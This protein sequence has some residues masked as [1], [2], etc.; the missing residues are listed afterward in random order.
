MKWVPRQAPLTLLLSASILYKFIGLKMYFQ[1]ILYM[2]SL[3]LSSR[4]QVSASS[5]NQNRED[6]GNKADAM[7]S[8]GGGGWVTE[9]PKSWS[10]FVEHMLNASIS[11][12]NLHAHNNTHQI[13]KNPTVP[14]VR[15]LDLEPPCTAKHSVKD[16]IAWRQE[17]DGREHASLKPTTML[18]NRIKH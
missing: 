9:S 8:A 11:C 14:K 4:L 6:L 5:G 16:M 2:D 13:R 15:A 1:I 10:S 7:D 12:A 3:W 17:W 18:M